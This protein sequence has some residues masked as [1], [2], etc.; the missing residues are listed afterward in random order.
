MPNLNRALIDELATGCYI[1]EKVPVRI[2]GSCGTG[3]SHLAEGLGHCAVRQGV[4]TQCS[5][6]VTQFA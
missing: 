1:A 2:A 3:K 4:D 6:P 5:Q